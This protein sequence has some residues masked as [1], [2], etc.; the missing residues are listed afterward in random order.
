V[1]MSAR[2][3]LQN[4]FLRGWEVGTITEL[5]SGVPFNPILGGDPTGQ[6]TTNAEDLPDRTCKQLTNPGN[7][8]EFIHL[9]CLAFPNPVNRYGNFRRNSAIGPGLVS[10]DAS[11]VKNTSIAERLNVQFR[12]EA[13][14]VINHAN[15]APPIDNQIVFDENGNPV[16]GAGQ[17]DQ[18]QT[19][20][21]EIQFA[22]KLIF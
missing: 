4:K 7:P 1:D 18:T 5:S 15:F 2:G 19:P 13:F 17:I 6:G 8:T 11:I 21:R 10:V 14:N 22:L 9:E 12:A 20:A 16:P 3:N